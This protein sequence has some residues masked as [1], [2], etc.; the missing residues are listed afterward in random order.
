MKKSKNWKSL[1]LAS[2]TAAMFVSCTDTND[3]VP[4]QGESEVIISATVGNSAESPNARTNNF[5]Y[6][7]ISITDVGISVDNIKLKLKVEGN[8][9]VP[10]E[11]PLSVNQSVTASLVKDGQVLV[12]PLVRG[13]AL[14]GVYG[15]AIFDLVKASNV[16]DTH[17]MHGY[18]VIAK[19][20]WFNIP[21][22]MY[23]DL[24]DQVELDFE[25]DFIVNGTQ[26]LVLTLYMDKLLEGVQP[27]WVS[28]GNSD[29]LIEVGPNDVDGNQEAYEAIK[30]N[31]RKALVFKEGDFQDN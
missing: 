23:L 14:Y 10:V 11:I 6:G 30:E 29:G 16:P 26:N 12:A 28:D 18:S 31:I 25:K 1:L 17:E 22:V 15:S 9:G 19:A 24:E 4:T 7:N 13:L 20:T 3:D 5:V 2:A 21:A 8:S 27:A